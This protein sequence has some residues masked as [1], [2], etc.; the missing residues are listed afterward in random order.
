MPEYHPGFKRQA[1]YG[2]QQVIPEP[3]VG[4]KPNAWQGV[5][6]MHATAYSGAL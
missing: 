5:A 3:L 4:H 1:L 2:R 6:S